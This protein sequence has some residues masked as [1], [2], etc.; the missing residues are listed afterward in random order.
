VRFFPQPHV[1]H[2]L[3]VPIDLEISTGKKMTA[4][5]VKKLRNDAEL[6]MWKS[7][8]RRDW[9]KFHEKTRK[10]QQHQIAMD[11]VSYTLLAHSFLLSHRQPS[12][13]ALLVLEEMKAADMHPAIIRI[14]ERLINSQLE[15][16]DMGI[17]P[18]SFA[19]QNLT[20]LCW[21]S[22]ARLRNTRA[23]RIQTKL[24]ALSTDDLFGLE[25]G[26]AAREMIADEH[27]EAREIVQD[28]YLEISDDE[29][30][31]SI[32]RKSHSYLEI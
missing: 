16:Q 10:F 30:A 23:K 15:L 29:E 20:R 13:A 9:D 7:L 1:A 17:R 21:M 32:S 2:K 31:L 5:A 14:N 8:V 24:K 12:S 27:A 11:E 22:A 28:E 6:G 19:W 18:T 4:E 3:Q 26:T 25:K